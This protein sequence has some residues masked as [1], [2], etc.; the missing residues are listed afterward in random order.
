M[1]VF[2]HAFEFCSP[3][4]NPQMP[5]TPNHANRRLPFRSLDHSDL[6]RH[7]SFKIRHSPFLTLVEAPSSSRLRALRGK[8]IKSLPYFAP[9]RKTP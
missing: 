7:L 4:N 1:R 9:L 6:S 2:E 8:K 5:Q 3:R